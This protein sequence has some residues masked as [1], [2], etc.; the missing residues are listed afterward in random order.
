[1]KNNFSKEMPDTAKKRVSPTFSQAKIGKSTVEPAEQPSVIEECPVAESKENAYFEDVAA[2]QPEP[3][4]EP[5]KDLMK[6][7]PLLLNLV[8][9]S[10]EGEYDEDGFFEGEGDI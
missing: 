10:Y 5:L 4:K 8:V 3:V 6:N 1:M 7:E 9:K 2:P